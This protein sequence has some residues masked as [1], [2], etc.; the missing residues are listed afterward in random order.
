MTTSEAF[1]LRRTGGVRILKQDAQNEKCTTRYTR[2][3]AETPACLAQ[4]NKDRFS[5][6]MPTNAKKSVLLFTMSKANPWKEKKGT[7]LLRFL[8]S[9]MSFKPRVLDHHC[10]TMS[11]AR[12]TIL[13]RLHEVFIDDQDDTRSEHPHR[14]QKVLTSSLRTLRRL[15]TRQNSRRIATPTKTLK[16]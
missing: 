3:Q 7:D 5:C 11:Q 16:K 15:R 8:F 1:V 2:P 9:N 6:S 4:E 14:S 10:Q 12:R 13:E